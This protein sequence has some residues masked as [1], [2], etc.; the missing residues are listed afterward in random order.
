MDK[1]EQI[2]LGQ[3]KLDE[4][5]RQKRNLD[6]TSEEWTQKKC[7][8]L[9]DEVGELLREV[10]YKWWKNPKTVDKDLVAGELVDILH[11]WVS[12]CLDFGITA[13]DIH[14]IYFD[15]N[16]ENFNRQDGLSEKEGYEI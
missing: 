9:L 2:F 11:F 3:A 7:L 16:K 10:N 6:F 4:Y 12:M 8:A 5:I 13:S 1:L 15:K 14:K